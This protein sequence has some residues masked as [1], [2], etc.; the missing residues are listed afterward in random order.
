MMSG[1]LSM[2]AVLLVTAGVIGSYVLLAPPAIGLANQADFGRFMEPFGITY[3]PDMPVKDRYWCFTDVTFAFSGK[4]A[5]TGYLSSQ[6]L[7]VAAG[8]ALNGLASKSPGFD[9]RFL[10]LIHLAV[11]LL[12]LGKLLGTIQKAAGYGRITGLLL[13]TLIVTDVGYLA[14]FNTFYSE[15]AVLLFGIAFVALLFDTLREPRL[16][17]VWLLAASAALLVTSKLQNAVLGGVIGAFLVAMPFLRRDWRRLRKAS[18][19]GGALVMGAGV[20]TALAAMGWQVNGPLYATVF[21]GVLLDS[22]NPRS[23]LAELGI[24]PR[25]EIYKGV[26]P[27]EPTNAQ[28]AGYFPG[29]CT[30]RR[31]LKFYVAHPVSLYRRTTRVLGAV[32][33]NHI[34]ELGNFQRGY[35]YLCAQHAQCFSIWDSIRARFNSLPLAGG[36]FLISAGIALMLAIRNGSAYSLGYL[37]LA[38]MAITSFYAAALGDG[39]DYRKHMLLFH[40]LFDGCFTVAAVFLVAR[41]RQVLARRHMARQ[42][43]IETPVTRPGRHPTRR[44]RRG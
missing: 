28:T 11:L 23:D 19:A 37:L 6:F 40:L 15:P 13:A 8:V 26:S 30:F 21:T 14:Y 4:R 5:R 35:G 43:G 32:M 7:F 31:V 1:F 39:A 17:S 27:F 29:H 20:L 41:S 2:R 16:W 18:M 36:F 3:P 22:D 44:G 9:I 12:F 38:A 24:D 33:T 10:A 42:A 34:P 25:A